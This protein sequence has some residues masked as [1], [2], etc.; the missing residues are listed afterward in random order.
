MQ[1]AV[2]SSES[3]TRNSLR[4]AHFRTA[5]MPAKT[6]A[7]RAQELLDE[8]KAAAAE[9]IAALDAALATAGT[10]AS[11]IAAGGEIYPDGVRDM[12]RRLNEDVSLK[13]KT[14]AVIVRKTGAF[15][16]RHRLD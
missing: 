12:C 4:Q 10:I 6:P 15:S 5:D 2:K 7:M 16:P 8:A 1:S 3:L 13:A 14:L 9:H 11:E